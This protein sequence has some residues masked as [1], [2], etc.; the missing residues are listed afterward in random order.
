MNIEQVGILV[1][2]LAD[3]V[4]IAV[5]VLLY[6]RRHGRRDLVLSFVAVN[7][8]VLV[9]TTALAN[10]PSAAGLGLGLF[11]I[12]SII[13]LRSDA[14]THEEI[15]YYFTALALGLLAGLHPGPWWFVAALSTFLVSL[16][17][18]ADHPRLLTGARRHT[19]VLDR[20]IIEERLLR[21]ELETMLQATV[22]HMVVQK[23]DFI[24][25]LT[26]VDV[27]LVTNAGYEGGTPSSLKPEHS[28]RST[29]IALEPSA[30]N[31]R[32]YAVDARPSQ[33]TGS[34]TT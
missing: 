30:S 28:A 33:V 10:A 3:L 8:G 27:R 13:R 2:V 25:D 9:V 26:V 15:A 18:V 24:L 31:S 20:A 4:A 6:Y 1:A 12:L 29:D 5:M 19:V 32:V 23:I 14:L 16:V 34:Q 17:A 21:T 22:K 11:G 7:A